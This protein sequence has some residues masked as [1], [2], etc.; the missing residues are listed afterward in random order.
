MHSWLSGLRPTERLK[1]VDAAAALV[2]RRSLLR[3]YWTAFSI[4]VPGAGDVL[5]RIVKIL[6][7]LELE[8]PEANKGPSLLTGLEGN[9]PSLLK[10]SVEPDCLHK[11]GDSTLLAISLRPLALL[12]VGGDQ[13]DAVACSGRAGQ[14]S[15]MRQRV[16][17]GF[18]YSDILHQCQPAQPK[19]ATELHGGMC[20]M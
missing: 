1:E 10:C 11:V 19:D 9:R 20:Q 8:V 17:P 6:Q 18:H 13:I 5:W 4:C 7:G 2:L 3:T 12:L 16:I 15:H 14:F